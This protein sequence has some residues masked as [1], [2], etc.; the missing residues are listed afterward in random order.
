MRIVATSDTHWQPAY[1]SVLLRT[2]REIAALQPDCFILAG[3]VGE[4]QTGFRNMLSVLQ[5]EI[6]CPRLIIPG[7]HDL[8]AT[9]AYYSETLFEQVLPEMVR[10][11]NAIWL[12]T[13]D[14]RCDGLAI[15][16]SIGWY[17][18][19]AGSPY[20]NWTDEQYIAA[21]PRLNNDGNLIKWTYTDKAFANRVGD[22]LEKRLAALQDDPD[23]REILV[24][25]HVPPFE[26]A[27]SPQPENL[28]WT[29][30]TAYFH[31]LTLG[32]RIIKYPKVTRV[33]SG[34]T[35]IGKHVPIKTAGGTIDFQVIDSDYGTPAVVSFDYDG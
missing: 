32:K 1:E 34:H 17:D 16:G 2:I 30:G 8:W 29:I 26:Q 14:W 33:L 25:T 11:H 12:E 28:L 22:A 35:H 27:I 9:G 5:R 15:C 3:D 23:V 19:S 13:D 20:L 7:N 4:G 10:E 31:N 18:Y 24:V 21:K 6:T